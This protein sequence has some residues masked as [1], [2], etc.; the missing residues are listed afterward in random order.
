MESTNVVYSDTTKVVVAKKPDTIKATSF[1]EKSYSKLNDSLVLEQDA[2][3]FDYL[4]RCNKIENCAEV[5]FKIPYDKTIKWK[6][7]N[8]DTVF[9]IILRK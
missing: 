9:T 2:I 3:S 4:Y 5:G 6:S 1:I 7:A 8:G